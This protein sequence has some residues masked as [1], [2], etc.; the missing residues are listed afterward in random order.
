MGQGRST[1]RVVTG[2]WS[3]EAAAVADKTR[4][5]AAGFVDFGD[6]FHRLEVVSLTNLKVCNA[7]RFDIRRGGQCP[8]LDY[9]ESHS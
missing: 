2:F 6:G 4:N 8:G 3:W 1:E 5:L 9:W 7:M